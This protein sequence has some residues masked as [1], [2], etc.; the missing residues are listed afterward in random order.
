MINILSQ[1]WN[2]KWWEILIIAAIDDVILF[3]KVWP[4]WVI[5]ILILT[6]TCIVKSKM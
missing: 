2:C 3:F 4:L 1:I 5:L 6:I